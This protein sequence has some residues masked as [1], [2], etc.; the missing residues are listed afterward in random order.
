[1]KENH[2][3]TVRGF[4]VSTWAL[5]AANLL[6]FGLLMDLIGQPRND[7]KLVFFGVGGAWRHAANG[8]TSVLNLGGLQQGLTLC[9]GDA[10]YTNWAIVVPHQRLT[11]IYHP[12]STHTYSMQ[13]ALNVNARK[14]A[15]HWWW[16]MATMTERQRKCIFVA[17]KMRWRWSSQSTCCIHSFDSD[18][19]C[20][21]VHKWH[22]SLYVYNDQTFHLPKWS[23]WWV[24]SPTQ[25]YHSKVEVWYVNPNNLHIEV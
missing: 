2:P 17:Q 14:W 10:H 24:F 25:R 23:Q 19:P 21:T 3:Y 12:L 8:R 5:P 9:T 22:S 20:S 18:S 15:S 1:M 16:F 6:V 4:F 11:L 7:M 13:S